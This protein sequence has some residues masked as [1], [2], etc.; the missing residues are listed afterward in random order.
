MW[1]RAGRRLFSCCPGGR[2]AVY[3]V[4]ISFKDGGKIRDEYSNWLASHHISEVLNFDGFLSAE[5]LKE[6]GGQGLVVR[7]TLESTDVF[8]K[9][10]K[11]EIAKKLRQDA[12]DRF[13]PVFTASR[14]VLISS[15]VF[16]K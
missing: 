2:G 5:L 14:K 10:D 9:Y 7:Y 8:E 11:S 13:G 16:Y 3:E 1:A 6:Y 4:S 15:D 12:I